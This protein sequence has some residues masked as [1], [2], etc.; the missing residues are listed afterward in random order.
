MFPQKPLRL[1][2]LAYSQPCQTSK[3]ERFLQL[4]M[5]KISFDDFWGQRGVEIN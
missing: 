2:V 3:M 5:G 1:S 4:V